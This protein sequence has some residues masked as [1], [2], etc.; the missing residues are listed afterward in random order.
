MNTI[1]IKEMNKDKEEIKQIKDKFGEIP[2]L[3]VEKNGKIIATVV[4]NTNISEGYEQGN[5]LESD[6][7]TKLENGDYVHI[8]HVAGWFEVKLITPIKAVQMI[9]RHRKYEL[10]ETFR[11][12]KL[13]VKLVSKSCSC[14][15]AE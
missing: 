11:L 14:K 12:N 1:E 9:L 6:G 2:F 8:E 13:A 15:V 3:D 7:I 10:I 4:A 5:F